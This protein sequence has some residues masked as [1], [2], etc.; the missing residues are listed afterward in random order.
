[1]T[2][3][4]TNKGIR[5]PHILGFGEE[6]HTNESVKIIDSLKDFFKPEFLNRID[7]III[8]N[9]LGENDLCKIAQKMLNDLAERVAENGITLTISDDTAQLLA[10]TTA[11]QKL[12]ARPLRREIIKQ[13]E[14]PLAE[15]ILKNGESATNISIEAKDSNIVILSNF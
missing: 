1:M 6:T 8:F 14:N 4:L 10:K 7:E 9:N 12:G 11:S 3:N 15:F 5:S 2:S 13:I